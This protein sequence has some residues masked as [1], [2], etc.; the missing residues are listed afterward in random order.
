MRIYV[1]GPMRGIPHYNFPAFDEAAEKIRLEGHKAIN[2]A[3]LDRE[4]GFH[5]EEL[6]DNWDW[7][8]YPPGTD[9]SEFVDRDLDALATCDAIYMLPGWEKSYLFAS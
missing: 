7:N 5:P 3:D 2:P 6:P 9:A 8:E 1:S 4:M